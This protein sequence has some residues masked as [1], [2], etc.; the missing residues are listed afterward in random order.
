MTILT[1]TW[2]S[3]LK[4]CVIYCGGYQTNF[5]ANK[6]V[7]KAERLSDTIIIGCDS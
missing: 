5:R 3:E 4:Q 6:K 1:K 2:K 7:W